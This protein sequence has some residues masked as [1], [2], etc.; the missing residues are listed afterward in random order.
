VLALCQNLLIH[1]PPT[2][3]S[4]LQ[5]LNHPTEDVGL[6]EYL[7]VAAV[8]SGESG[9]RMAI[10]S[11]K[12]I[13]PT[14]RLF[15]SEYL[16]DNAIFESSVPEIGALLMR[17]GDQR[18]T[19]NLLRALGAIGS[20]SALD[21]LE[22]FVGRAKD[23]E[24]QSTALTVYTDIAGAAA[25]PFLEKVIPAGAVAAEG[26]RSQIQRIHRDSTLVDRYE[27]VMRNDVDPA[28]LQR[29]ASMPS[30]KW[31]QG[32]GL[33]RP[34][35]LDSLGALS[36]EK[37]NVLLDSLAASRGLGIWMVKGTL[38]RSLDTADLPKLLEMRS[39]AYYSPGT[40]SAFRVRTIAG[41]IRY[42]RQRGARPALR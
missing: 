14:W 7:Q 39:R 15:W 34:G 35:A 22:R 28:G 31:I 30:V 13:D 4:F 36:V 25:L 2:G 29:L 27:L 18:V 11:L 1:D 21:V 3:R 10:T 37:K 40:Y 20:R 42:I 33:L 19:A 8:V 32:E 6:R 26:R 5:V 41:L 9:E 23:D 16:R 17:S 24:L 38:A 12:S